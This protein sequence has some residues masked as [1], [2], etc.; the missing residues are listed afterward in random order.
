MAN[1][2]QS[3]ILPIGKLGSCQPNG[4]RDFYQPVYKNEKM[5]TGF[6]PV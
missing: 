4:F 6:K 1:F 2:I 5:K 3:K